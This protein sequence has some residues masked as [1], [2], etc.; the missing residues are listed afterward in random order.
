MHLVT[1]S[2]YQSVWGAK[3][4]TYQQGTVQGQYTRKNDK[5]LTTKEQTSE[6]CSNLALASA[7]FVPGTK[8]FCPT[9]VRGAGIFSPGWYYQPGLI[10]AGTKAFSP[11]LGDAPE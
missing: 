1:Y 9:V 5:G 8:G 10:P 7:F 3:E 11:G 4:K 2:V 6:R